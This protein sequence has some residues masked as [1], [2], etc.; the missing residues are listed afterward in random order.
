MELELKQREQ[1]ELIQAKE[2]VQE[3]LV[4]EQEVVNLRLCIEL[5]HQ[6]CCRHEGE[7][8]LRFG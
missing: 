3:T 1:R 2:M 8:W 5:E 7:R 4:Q 6:A